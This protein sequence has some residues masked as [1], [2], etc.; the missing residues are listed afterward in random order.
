MNRPWRM[1]A[2]Y[3]SEAQAATGARMRATPG[4]IEAAKSYH[5]HPRKYR[6][7]NGEVMK[8][9]IAGMGAI[10]VNAHAPTKMV[11]LFLFQQ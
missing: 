10:V 5:Y 11:S 7:A 1:S 4:G 9:C 3:R 2:A 6:E 8:A